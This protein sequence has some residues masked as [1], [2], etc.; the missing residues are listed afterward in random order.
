MTESRKNSRR[1]STSEKNE[2]FS[3][4]LFTFI[5]I[6]VVYDEREKREFDDRETFSRKQFN[7]IVDFR[8]NKPTVLLHPI[9]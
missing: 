3:L 9:R 4:V 1:F 8:L 6:Y 2:S 5:N 7:Y